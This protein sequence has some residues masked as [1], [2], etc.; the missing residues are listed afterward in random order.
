MT[1]VAARRVLWAAAVRTKGLQERLA[2]IAGAD[3]THT[4]VFPV[5]VATWRGQGLSDRQIARAFDDAGVAVLTIDPFL[6]WS[7]GFRVDDYPPGPDRDFV[8]F[9]EDAVFAMAAALRA[10]QLNLVSGSTDALDLDT[11]AEALDRLADHAG[12]EGVALTFEFMPISNVPD[13]R[14][15]LA[16]L[17]RM[18]HPIGLTFDTWH[19]ERSDPD[20]D[21]LGTLD[22]RRVTEVQLADA[23]RAP[24]GDLMNDLQHHRKVPGEGDFDLDRVVK[25]LRAS[26]AWRSVGPE[27]FS[28]E[29]DAL[30]ADAAVARALQGL[31]RF[32]R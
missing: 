28:D 5:D 23:G 26:G 22:G 15:A 3:F 27:I 25:V 24:V 31:D 19:F 32:D 8:D 16:L 17:D 9:D 29:M 6:Q 13:L 2:A 1:G 10:P 14:T 11:S 4:S 20:L 21:L 12:R 18:A 7:P 30:P